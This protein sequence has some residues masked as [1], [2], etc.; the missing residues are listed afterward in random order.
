MWTDDPIRDFE[1]YDAEKCKMKPVCFMCEEEIND[2]YFYDIY[3]TIYCKDCVY[4]HY[5]KENE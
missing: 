4:E 2:D 3:G 5:R 1:R